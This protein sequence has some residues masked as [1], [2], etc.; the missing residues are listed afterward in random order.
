MSLSKEVEEGLAKFTFARLQFTLV[1]LEEASLPPFKG[2]VFRSGLG[3][4]L[5]RLACL[6]PRQEE[7]HSCSRNQDCIY[8]YIF[9]TLPPEDSEIFTGCNEIPRPFVISVTD[10]RTVIPKDGILQFDLTLIGKATESLPYFII[11]FQ[12]LGELGIGKGRSKYKIRRVSDKT[13]DVYTDE[14]PFL[15]K[16]VIGGITMGPKTCTGLQLAFETP[17]RLRYQGEI[18]RVPEFHIILRN[19]L[20]RLSL[21]TY[22]HLGYQ[23]DVDFSRLIERAQEVRLVRDDTSWCTLQRYSRRQNQS[24]SLSGFT[25]RAEYL[26]ELGQFLPVLALGQEVHVGKSTVIGLGKYRM[27]LVG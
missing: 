4:I 11:A 20:R 21:L 7:C 10:S 24:V 13:G 27:G 26:G 22:F 25:G 8:C 6:K 15:R 9:N 1:F 17:L 3:M 14:S 18:V 23:L 5:R 12:Q 16:P 19:L 2:N